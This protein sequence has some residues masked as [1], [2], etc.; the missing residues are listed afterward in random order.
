MTL[1]DRVLQCPVFSGELRRTSN[2]RHGC[3]AAEPHAWRAFR[4]IQQSVAP[5]RATLGTRAVRSV[6]VLPG[7]SAMQRQTGPAP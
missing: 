1:P 2:V 7:K 5:W 3:E 6:G 4:R